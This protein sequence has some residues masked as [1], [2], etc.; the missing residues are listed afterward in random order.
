MKIT[1]KVNGNL[2]GVIDK[3]NKM[4]KD[5]PAMKKE[6]FE[7]CC[8]VLKSLANQNLM[9][10]DIGEDV[11]SQI[12]TG[13]SY[14]VTENGAVLTNTAEKAVFVEFGV[15]VVGEE[16][17]HPNAKNTTPEVYDY[18]RPTKFKRA[19]KYHDENT[20]RFYKNDLEEVDLQEGY[21]E[22]W[23][24]Q[25]GAIKIITKG[26]PATMYAFNSI[27]QF[28]EGEYAKKIWE[29]IKIKYWG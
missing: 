7:Q 1:V 12:E 14:V 11:K 4:K 29:N 23:Y 27:I 24:T 20:W 9:D 3:L 19:G 26:S 5:L 18:N 15:G 22:A 10:W 17:P 16:N 8:V 2:K 25:D 13:W 6:L 28:V 21:Y